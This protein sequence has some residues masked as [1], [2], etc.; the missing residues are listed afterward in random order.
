MLII[1]IGLCIIGVL[2]D[3]V[4]H[5]LLLEEKLGDTHAGHY[6]NRIGEEP[7]VLVARDQEFCVARRDRDA[8]EDHT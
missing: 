3:C 4:T 6:H 8:G 2:V 7:V 5:M 1:V